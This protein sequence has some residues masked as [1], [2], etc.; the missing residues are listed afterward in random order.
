M[1]DGARGLAAVLVVWAHTV[2][3]SGPFYQYIFDPGKIGV[4][5]F[6]FISG[7]LVI[8]SAARK[9]NARSF[10][11][12][13]ALRLYP[14]YWVS[15]VVAF[16]LWST[17][18]AW[19]TWVANITM[20]QQLMGF[21]NV[22]S[23]YWTLT[24]EFC[25]Y[26]LL[27]GLLI[28]RPST[29]TD[30]LRMITVV[31]FAMTLTAAFLRWYLEVRVPVA[32]PLGLFCMFIGAQIR[33]AETVRQGLRSTVPLY[34]ACVVPSCLLAYSFDAQ[35]SETPSR[36]LFSYLLGGAAF[37]LMAANVDRYPGRLLTFMGDASYGIYLFHFPVIFLVSQRLHPG[38]GQFIVVL[39][40]STLIAAVLYRLVEK[41][42]I[43]LGKRLTSR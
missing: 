13:R 10:L 3:K 19:T 36:Y 35:F 9:P 29:L 32:I 12:N 38:I 1:I 37:V 8:P 2:D 24:I 6:F 27:C 4:I 41:P 11:I 42:A 31:L 5:V 34:L 40:V 14:L 43:R 30:D 17:R 18:Y 28:L 26:V 16:A 7:Y 23:A 15:I 39:V 25:L 21:P 20:A 33:N 22:I